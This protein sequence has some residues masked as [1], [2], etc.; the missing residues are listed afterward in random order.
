M[1]NFSKGRL[2]KDRRIALKMTQEELA[3]D[4][5]DVVTLRRYEAGK[6]EPSDEKFNAIMQKLNVDS[7]LINPSFEIYGFTD[8]AVYEE[9]E[10]LLQIHELSEFARQRDIFLLSLNKTIKGTTYQQLCVRIN[11]LSENDSEKKINNLTEALRLTFSDFNVNKIPTKMLSYIELAIIN[12][13]AIC[14]FSMNNK[15]E[16]DFAVKIYNNLYNYFLNMMP[17]NNNLMFRKI[18]LNYTSVLGQQQQFEKAILICKRAIFWSDNSICQN[19]IYNLL[20]NLGWLYYHLGVSEDNIHYMLLSKKYL[21]ESYSLNCFFDES[22][23]G[24]KIIKE[25]YENWFGS[26]VQEEYH[27]QLEHPL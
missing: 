3:S 11:A 20:Y 8:P 27:M 15:D 14:Y 9:F 26:N 10:R 18:V 17:V 16:V 23:I 6:L 25:N 22:E 1:S 13:I 5:C 24:R 7:D 12:D 19:N 21:L 4:I 2:I